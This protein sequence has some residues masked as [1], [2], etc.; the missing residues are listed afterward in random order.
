MPISLL[1]LTL[2]APLVKTP[3][4]YFPCNPFDW[5]KSYGGYALG[6][7]FLQAAFL[8]VNWQ[9]DGNGNWFLAQAPGPNTPSQAVAKS[10]ALDDAFVEPSANDWA[11]TW[12]GAWTPIAGAATAGP[13]GSDAA[14]HTTKHGSAPSGGAIAGVAVGSVLAAGILIGAVVCYKK[15][16]KRS[17]NIR[18]S[19]AEEGEW[20]RKELEASDVKRPLEPLEM[21][22]EPLAPRELDGRS[23]HVELPG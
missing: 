10:I 16:F 8:G 18:L 22:Y 11:D 12:K 21:A 23:R 6:K 17:R 15:S 5:G 13:M 2:T 3:T 14:G 20:Q 4:Q 19:A 9:L 1:K 7:A